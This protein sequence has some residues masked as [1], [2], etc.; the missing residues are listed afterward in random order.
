MKKNSRLLILFLL[1]M[2]PS[3]IN[4]MELAKYEPSTPIKYEDAL[5][6]VKETM[7][8]YYIRGPYIQ[9]NNS[10]LNIQL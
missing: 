1:F 6:V 4:A 9:Y 8:S 2:F 3:I 7:K 10:K 5:K